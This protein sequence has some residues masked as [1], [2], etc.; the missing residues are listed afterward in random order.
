M[1]MGADN[2][3]EAWEAMWGDDYRIG[4]IVQAAAN[5][6]NLYWAGWNC[7]GPNAAF[8]TFPVNSIEDFQGTKMWAGAPQAMFIQAMCGV[9]V[10]LRGSEIYMS[11][12]LGT[13]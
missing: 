4:D 7:Q 13:S 9:P 8:T 5:E 10:S 2:Y 1:A 6:Q 11:R 12:I 3:E